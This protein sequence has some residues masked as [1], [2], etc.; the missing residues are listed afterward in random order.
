MARINVVLFAPEIPQ[1]TGNIMRTCVGTNVLL[2]LIKPLGFD[3]DEKSL[4]RAGLDYLDDL[5]FHVYENLEEFF[6]KRK[7]RF[8]YLTRYGQKPL[9]GFDFKEVRDDIY[10]VFGNESKGLP[11]LLL[12]SHLEYCFRIP[13][14][15]KIRTLNLSNCVAIAVYEVLRQLDY[16]GLLFSDLEAYKGEN[17]LK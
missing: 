3:I 14:S 8:F 9:S 13:M 2:H 11:N 1:N 17:I 12:R 15:E 10:L 6:M 7:G 16:P 5:K 4:R